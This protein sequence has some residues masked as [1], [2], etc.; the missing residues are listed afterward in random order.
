LRRVT[1]FSAAEALGIGET[2]C[3]GTFQFHIFLSH[4]CHGGWLVSG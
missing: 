3:N 1:E 4:S 2:T